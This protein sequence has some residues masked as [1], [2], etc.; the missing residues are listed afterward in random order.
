LNRGYVKV[1]RKIEDSGLIQLP[2]TLALFMHILLRATHKDTK[3]GTTTGVIEL[4]RGQFISGIHKLSEAL[5]QTERQIRT[6]IDR[7]VKLGIITVKATNKYSVYTIENYSLYQDNDTLN[8]KQ[9]TDKEQSNDKETTTKQEFNN[10]NIKELKQ[11]R[12]KKPF[13][14]P[15]W[16]NK[17]H[18]DIWHLHPKRKNLSAEHKELAVKQLQAWKEKGID[19]AKALEASATNNW[20]GLFEPKANFAN[21]KPGIEEQNRKSTAEAKLKLFG[22][23]EKDVTDEATRI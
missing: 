9:T 19:Y 23:Q 20:Q 4:K 12:T 2:N 13:V 18:W 3:R 7:L 11:G 1:W 21:G 15:D 14:L 22:V 8:D 16:I 5:E 17:E 10:L 6:S